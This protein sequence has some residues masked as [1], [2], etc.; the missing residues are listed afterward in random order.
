MLL[1]L[2]LLLLPWLLLVRDSMNFGSESVER[3]MKL[4]VIFLLQCFFSVTFD[5]LR[6]DEAALDCCCHAPV[7][8][9]LLSTSADPM[10]DTVC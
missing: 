1:L 10:S 4:D 2:I 8:L 5:P 6:R 7:C 9:Y 3:F